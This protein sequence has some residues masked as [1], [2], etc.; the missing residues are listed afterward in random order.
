MFTCTAQK[1]MPGKTILLSS[2]ELKSIFKYPLTC[3]NNNISSFHKNLQYSNNRD[4][5]SN[6]FS[7][8]NVDI[9]NEAGQ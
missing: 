7:N 5:G 6:D 4:D 1:M 2:I 8:D 9:D 3:N